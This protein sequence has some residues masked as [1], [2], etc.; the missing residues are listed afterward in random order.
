MHTYTCLQRTFRGCAVCISFHA[1]ASTMSSLIM[2]TAETHFPIPAC[3]GL[4]TAF[5]LLQMHQHRS[6]LNNNGQEQQAS[7]WRLSAYLLPS[8][9]RNCCLSRLCPVHHQKAMAAVW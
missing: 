7:G 6:T 1:A 2:L 9:M 4:N 5:V 8:L 3:P